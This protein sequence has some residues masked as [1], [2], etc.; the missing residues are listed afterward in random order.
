VPVI[1]PIVAIVQ[2]VI[3]EAVDRPVPAGVRP[4]ISVVKAVIA[5]IVCV[6]AVMAVSVAVV[7]GRIY[8]AAQRQ[9][10][11]DAR[12]NKPR[13]FAGFAH[14]PF[15][16]HNSDRLTLRPRPNMSQINLRTGDSALAAS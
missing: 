13:L 11:C 6:V 12:R 3:E 1:I 16:L 5:V 10:R 2:P 8:A 7:A 9:K 15:P 4:I 14:D